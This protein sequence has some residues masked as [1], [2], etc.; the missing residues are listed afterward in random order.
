MK[1]AVRKWLT[2]ATPEQKRA[3]AKAAKTSVEQLK[4]LGAGRR[5]ASAELSQ[6]LSRASRTLKSKALVLDQ[7]DLCPA[8]HVC[9]LVKRSPK[10]A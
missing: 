8:C 5:S 4:H 10:A 6:R 2:L 7:R 1:N 9:P 3:L